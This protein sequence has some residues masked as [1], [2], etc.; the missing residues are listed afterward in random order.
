[1]QGM[2]RNAQG[3]PTLYSDDLDAVARWFASLP[4]GVSGQ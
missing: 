3:E 2:A 1:M 4:K